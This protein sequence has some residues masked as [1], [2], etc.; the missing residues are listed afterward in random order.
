MATD[1]AHDGRKKAHLKMRRR[2]QVK[3]LAWLTGLICSFFRLLALVHLVRFVRSSTPVSVGDDRKEIAGAPDIRSGAPRSL[4]LFGWVN[5][6]EHAA[7]GEMSLLGK[8][9]AT[10]DF[11]DGKQCHGRKLVRVFLGERWNR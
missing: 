9:P 5:L 1:H 2:F 4:Y 3:L 6:V 10:G 8:G 11:I 7:I